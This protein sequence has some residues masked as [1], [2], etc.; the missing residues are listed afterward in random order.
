MDDDRTVRPDDDSANADWPKQTPDFPGMTPQD[1]V[2][3]CAAMGWTVEQFLKMPG[4]SRLP[5]EM[6]RRI[7]QAAR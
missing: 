5:D 2:D 3:H 1:F 6:K 4:P 7:R